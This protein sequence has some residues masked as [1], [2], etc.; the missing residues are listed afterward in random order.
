MFLVGLLACAA[1]APPPSRELVV[2][3]AVLSME[4][5]TTLQLAQA[6]ID[7]DGKGQG[8]VVSALSPG[9]PP[10]QIDAPTSDWDLKARSARF[11][12][13][14]TAVRGDVT[15]TCQVLKVQFASADRVQTAIAEGDV[16]VR[17]GARTASGARAELNADTG[18]IALTGEPRIAEGANTMTGERI[19]LW[20]DDDR[21]RC[22]QCRLVVAGDA[23]A[24]RGGP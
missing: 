15:L 23:I 22:D 9:T 13:G 11:T 18:E 21:V 2:E 16:I 3:Q 7:P 6:T 19:A 1:S 5:G 20:L 10:L 14:V 17:Q 12:G 24:P 8:K 4:D